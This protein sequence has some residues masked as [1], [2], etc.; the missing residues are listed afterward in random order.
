MLD[1]SFT[2]KGEQEGKEGT[3]PTTLQGLWLQ[4]Q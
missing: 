1:L 2:N 3:F 4:S